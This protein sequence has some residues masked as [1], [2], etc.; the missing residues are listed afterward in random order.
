M[1]AGGVISIESSVHCR[2]GVRQAGRTVNGAGRP[3]GC[4][5]VIQSR[6]V[7]RLWRIIISVIL[8]SSVASALFGYLLTP[9]GAS[10]SI[11]ALLGVANALAIATPI[12]FFETSSAR[13]GPL[14]RLPLAAYFGIKTV[15]YLIVILGGLTLVRFVFS[16]DTQPVAFDTIFRSSIFFAVGMTVF[17]NLFFEMGGLL[18]FGTLKSL[19]TG[20]YVQPKREHRAF[21]LLDM[22]DSTGF[23]DDSRQGLR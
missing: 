1:W 2:A 14:R 20:R 5:D 7:R 19:V 23:L 22:K 17:G 13:V 8:S 15:F 21:L 10:H 11:S 3:E 6:R 4:I 16:S 9:T 18:G 12:V